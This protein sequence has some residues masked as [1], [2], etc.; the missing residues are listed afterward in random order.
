MRR[1]MRPT[2]K[3]MVIVPNAY[4]LGTVWRVMAYG[5][6]DDQGQEGVT[7]FRT[8][9][10]WTAMMK[11]A[12]FDITGLRG[13]NGEHH[14]AWYFKRPDGVITDRE[15]SWRAFLNTFV[16]PAI[17]LNLSQCFVYFLRRQPDGP[18]A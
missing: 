9:N 11:T 12:G 17:P 4:Y 2:G 14:I 6:A 18:V 5:E 16:K 3:A 15:R 7:D 8:I 13:Y 10:D 1:I